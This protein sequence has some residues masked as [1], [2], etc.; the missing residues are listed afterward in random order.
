MIET[1]LNDYFQKN[2]YINQNKFSHQNT[3][4]S[5]FFYIF[6]SEISYEDA[7]IKMI[8]TLA[9]ENII[10]SFS[11]FYNSVMKRENLYPTKYDKIWLPHP[12]NAMAKKTTFSVAILKK[13]KSEIGI[14][15]LS[16]INEKEHEI[17]QIILSKISYLVQSPKTVD[18]I[19]RC[20]QIMMNL[21]KFLIHLINVS[22]IL[23]R[24]Y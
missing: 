10:S 20:L 6:D 17:M 18:Q 12:L 24:I 1:V 7:L 13:R 4:E 21:S 15:F 3:I 23:N 19:I 2:S 8:E 16:A 22:K 14:I 5:K 11:A 9:K